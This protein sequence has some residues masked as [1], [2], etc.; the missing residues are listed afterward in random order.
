MNPESIQIILLITSMIMLVMSIVNPVYGVI[1]YFIIMNAKIGDMY[2]ALGAIRFE[3]L[4][5]I[6]V[7]S[8]ILI[9]GKGFKIFLPRANSINDAFWILIFTGFLSLIFS[10]DP[11]VSWNT[12]GYL[13]LKVAL[14]Y[15][16]VVM[17]INSSSDILK[18]LWAFMLVA[19]WISYEPIMNYL[20]GNVV[21][22]GYGDVAY[23]RFGVAKGHVAL[24][25]TLNQS[26][27]LTFYMA[28]T[29]KN[30]FLKVS[31]FAILVMLGFGVY[32][33]KSRGG[34]LGLVAI[35]F[36]LIFLT[37]NRS[38]AVIVSMVA[39]I[40]FLSAAGTAYLHHM[41][42]IGQGI[43]G[44]RTT[45]DRYLGLVNGISMMIKRPILGVGVGCYAEARSRYFHYYFFSHNLYG[46]LFGELGIASIAWFYW[47]Y[48]M[49][50]RSNALKKGLNPLKEKSHLYYNLLNGIQLGIVI[51][52]ILGNFSH[53]WY[54]WFWF[55]M[56][57]L[58]VGIEQILQD[59]GLLVSESG[60]K[61]LYHFKVC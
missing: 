54:I 35:S 7:F 17:T 3:L 8:T 48:L 61:N 46:E 43:Y 51:R 59:E 36:G 55:M 33:S 37:K 58:I 22:Y 45:A 38:R 26:I 13:F 56:A 60:E 2:P 49:L 19:A 39:T 9:S 5:A 28:L 24:A 31:L 6:Y 29:T 57:A 15:I 1:S 10:I 32:V 42:T 40:I 30:K 27:P 53:G 11:S 21:L 23:G 16:M 52:L 41:S 14:F 47:V 44:S 18:L 50:K 12:G 34:F 4:V 25:N 20:N